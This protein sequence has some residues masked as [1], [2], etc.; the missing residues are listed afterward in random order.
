MPKVFEI[1]P[2][3]LI[4]CILQYEAKFKPYDMYTMEEIEKE[5]IMNGGRNLIGPSSSEENEVG[6]PREGGELIHNSSS[7]NNLNGFN[8]L[9]EEK[10]KKEIESALN[11]EGGGKDSKKGGAKEKKPEEKKKV[12]PKKDKKQLEEEERKRKKMKNEE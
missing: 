11:F 3:S 7:H 2:D 12:E 8:P 1:E 6:S 9:L 5:L 10:V 4:T